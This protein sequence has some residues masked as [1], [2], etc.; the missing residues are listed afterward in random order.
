M[1]KICSA[2]RDPLHIN[3][4]LRTG[5][6]HS[7]SKTRAAG[8]NMHSIM[9]TFLHELKKFP[10]ILMNERLAQIFVLF[11]CETW[12]IRL[13]TFQIKVFFFFQSTLTW[14]QLSNVLLVNFTLLNRTGCV[15]QCEPSAGLSG[16]RYIR[17]VLCGS[18][19]PAGTHCEPEN[20]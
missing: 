14:P 15:C 5:V 6:T 19:P 2:Q 18:A 1:L 7:R 8:H 9:Q 20:L 17:C 16:C 4:H 10:K 11:Y 13:S 3:N 12:L